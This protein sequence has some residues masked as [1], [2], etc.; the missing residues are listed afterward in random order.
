MCVRARTHTC[1]CGHGNIEGQPADSVCVDQGYR[2]VGGPGNWKESERRMTNSKVWGK[3]ERTANPEKNG[4]LSVTTDNEGSHKDHGQ[5]RVEGKC[6]DTTHM[7]RACLQSLML[8][9]RGFHNLLR[10]KP[11]DEVQCLLLS[12]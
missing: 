10:V 4:S 6:T 11:W 8:K 7:V 12:W 3:Q 2:R 5:R 1:M 9:M